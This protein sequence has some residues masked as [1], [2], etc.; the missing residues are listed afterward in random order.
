MRI[1]WTLGYLRELAAIGDYLFEH[2]P[3]AAARIVR[4]IHGRTLRLL[5][6]MH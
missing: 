2:N 3:S 1:F 4:P 6:Q 5:T